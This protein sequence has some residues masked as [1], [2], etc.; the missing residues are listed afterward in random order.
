MRIRLIQKVIDI[1]RLKN[2]P[3]FV[4]S[5]GNQVEITDS[6]KKKINLNIIGKN[7]I[8]KIKT[9]KISGCISINIFGDN[10]SILIDENVSVSQSLSI[11]IGQNHPNFGKVEN[12]EVI[13]GKNTSI[14]QLDYITYNSNTY[15]KIGENCMISY[16]VLMYNTDGHPVFEKDTK[17]IINNIEGISI[18]EHSWIGMHVTILKNSFIP[19]NSVIGCNSTFTGRKHLQSNCAFAGNPAR[20][21]RNNIDWDSNGNKYG[22]I[23]NKKT[24]R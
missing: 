13:I 16:G 11:L 20:V 2:K 23:D 15:C 21:I 24:E 8:I 5:K 3:S 19:Q 4:V 17:K 6:A 14:E 12:S 10:N 7:N 22:Y 9:K 1:I 18:G